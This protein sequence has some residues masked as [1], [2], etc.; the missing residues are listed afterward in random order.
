[1]RILVTGSQGKVG[2][3]T[4]ATLAKE[5]H[6]V[7][8]TDLSRGVYDTPQGDTFAATYIQ[9]DL[10]DAGAVFAMIARFRPDAVVHIAAIPGA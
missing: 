2:S 1:M 3:V 6:D 7:I 9:A 8:G 10:E 4:C 5:G